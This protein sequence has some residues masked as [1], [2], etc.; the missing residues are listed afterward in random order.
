VIVPDFDLQFFQARVSDSNVSSLWKSL[1]CNINPEDAV[2]SLSQI[3][4]VVSETTTVNN[5]IIALD[6]AAAAG[7]SFTILIVSKIPAANTPPTTTAAESASKTDKSYNAS[8]LVSDNTTCQSSIGTSLVV[9]DPTG[10]SSVPSAGS[11]FHHC[12]LRRN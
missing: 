6:R 2:R 5:G 3:R 1:P 10:L 11:L 8:T 9:T 7:L 12:L 4:S